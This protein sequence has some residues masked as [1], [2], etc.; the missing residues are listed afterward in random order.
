[1]RTVAY[2]F[3]KHPESFYYEFISVG[4]KGSIKKVVEFFKLQDL[5]AEIFNLAFGDWDEES[6]RIIDL[7][8]SNNADKEKVLSTVAATVVDF[9]K[10]HSYAIIVAIGSTLSRTR[11]YQMGIDKVLT[12]ICQKFEVQDI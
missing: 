12:E 3:K 10:D 9:I 6:N 4:P 5:N 8:I 7:S 2:P 11:L 1:M